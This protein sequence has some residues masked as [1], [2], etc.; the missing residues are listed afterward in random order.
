M[1]LARV[2]SGADALTAENALRLA[3]TGGATL[4]GRANE[5]GSLEV[6]KAADLVLVDVSGID[7]AGALADPLAAL[8]FTG[9]SQ[10]VHTTI[11]N[12]AIVVRDGRLAR[13]DEREIAR[14]VNAHSFRLLQA[15]GQPLPWG[16]PPWV[17]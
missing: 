14:Q 17:R 7:R 11:V 16:V 15:A 5:I 10:R 1:L 12:G 6:G 8:V 2:G 13:E 4:L 9:M 3:T